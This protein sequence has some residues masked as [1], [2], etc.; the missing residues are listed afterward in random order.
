MILSKLTYRQK[1]ISLVVGTILL[2]ILSYF[3]SINKTIE[4]SKAIKLI[5]QRILNAKDAPEQ[6]DKLNREISEWDDY[7]ISK[8]SADEIQL[9]VFDEISKVDSEQHVKMTNIKR[10]NTIKE[11]DI[12]ID[13]Y[14]IVFSGD[15]KA[16]VK[17]LYYLEHNMRYG[18]ILSSG[19]ELVNNRKKRTDEL[20]LQI[21]VQSMI[22]E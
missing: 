9:R 20:K 15:F 8:I 16:L 19:F 3:L 18:Y 6:I 21:T 1:S 7:V 13:T 17:T 14:E 10:I 22:K 4:I 12:S 2:L 11:K 5:D